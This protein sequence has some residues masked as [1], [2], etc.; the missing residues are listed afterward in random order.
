MGRTHANRETDYNVG[1][2][3]S[4]DWLRRLGIGLVALAMLA[5]AACVITATAQAKVKHPQIRC[6]EGYV[7]HVVRVP[8]RKHGR[9]VRVHGKIVFERVQRCVKAKKRTPDG[10]IFMGSTDPAMEEALE[11]LE[12][13]GVHLDAMRI[14]AFPFSDDVFGFI[15]DHEQVFVVEQNRDAQL[16]SLLVNE[17]GV[18]P[19]QFLVPMRTP[20]HDP[21]AG[22]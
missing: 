4:G 21:G 2:T 12:A 14:R 1:C 18:H 16:K 9:I 7:R 10:V 5:C 13:R 3:R 8:K 22:Y 15:R 19:E 20:P 11:T 17:G 6:R